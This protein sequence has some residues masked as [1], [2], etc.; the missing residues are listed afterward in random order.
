M[1][2]S[3]VSLI[4]LFLSVVFLLFLFSKSFTTFDSY[5]HMQVAKH[6]RENWFSTLLQKVGMVDL[7]TYPPLAHQLLAIIPLPLEINY[8]LLTIIFT[9]LLSFYS[10]KFITSYLKTKNNFWLVYFFVLFSPAILITI[11]T[12]GQLPTLIGLAF[13]FISLYYFSEFLNMKRRDLLLLASLSLV[14]VAYTNILIFLILAIFYFFIFLFFLRFIIRNLKSIFSYFFL[15]A[16]LIFLIYYP[17]F[18]KSVVQKEI[19]HW[20]R[21]PFE[22]NLNAQRFIKMYGIAFP[23]S[24]ILPFMIISLNKKIRKRALEIYILAI[25]FLILSLGTTTPL[26]K[27]FGSHAYWLTYER[28]LLTSSIIFLSL[29][30]AL[31]PKF[32]IIF[33]NRKIPVHVFLTIPLLIFISTNLL[34]HEHAHFFGDTIKR[35]DKNIRDQ[36]TKFA[37]DYLNNI[38]GNYRYQTFGYDRPIGEIYFYSK[39]PTLDT[40]YFTGRTIS[41]I[42]ELGIEEID[43]IKDETMLDAFLNHATNYSIK[44]VIT[45]DDFYFNYFQSKGWELVNQN[46]FEGKKV[47]IFV[48]P[49]NVEEVKF[50]KESYG[51]INYLRGILPLALLTTFLIIVIK[52]KIQ[53]LE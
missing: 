27:F 25:I 7:S 23:V 47:A 20:S 19:P 42:R 11:F 22:D 53:K 3:L 48:N 10:A 39:L 29:C 40:D 36:Y 35:S 32:E 49:E 50:S 26:I 6:Y 51:F 5:F 52:T 9:I 24:L 46:I 44:Y 2:K 16:F 34:L 33:F 13:S 4:C 30:A 37:L 12:F 45:F 17:F 18:F 38:E 14:L 31:L 41:W 28:F 8:S 1:M 21:Y 43:Q 15:S